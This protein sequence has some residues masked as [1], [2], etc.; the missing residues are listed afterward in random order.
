MPVLVRRNIK[1]GEDLVFDKDEGFF[2]DQIDY[3]MMQF[4]DGKWKFNELFYTLSNRTIKMLHSTDSVYWFLQPRS[5]LNYLL[6]I[7]GGVQ[8]SITTS[9]FILQ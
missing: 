2:S 4:I 6:R 1:T 8:R 9:S 7:N 3:R 5:C